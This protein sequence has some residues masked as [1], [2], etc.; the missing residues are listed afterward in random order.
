MKIKLVYLYWSSRVQYVN[1]FSTKFI[2]TFVF[3]KQYT[4]QYE[5]VQFTK[6]VNKKFSFVP[7]KI[8]RLFYEM[9]AE[10]RYYF[11]VD[12]TYDFLRCW[13]GMQN[14]MDASVRRHIP[15]RI[16]LA[17]Y[18][19]RVRAHS[20]KVTLVTSTNHTLA[21]MSRSHRTPP[22]LSPANS[23]IPTDH[24]DLKL[25]LL[26]KAHDYTKFKNR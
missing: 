20:L 19:V 24:V 11:E 14:L 3:T 10:K 23:K 26:T 7:I 1:T 12:C 4:K 16:N 13:N 15:G 21:P 17:E 22:S 8:I 6:T 2:A 9:C 18:C 25:Y 5:T